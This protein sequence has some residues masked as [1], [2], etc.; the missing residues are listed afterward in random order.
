MFL[1]LSVSHSVHRGW[2]SAPL[3]SGI[4]LVGRHPHPPRQTTPWAGT[5]PPA[6][7][8]LPGRHTPLG[9]H[10]YPLSRHPLPPLDTT[11]YGQQAGGMHPTGIHTSKM[12]IC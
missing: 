11:G 6:D 3:H 9:R 8:P 12:K 1:H 4:H 10:P 2:V 7:T 5:P